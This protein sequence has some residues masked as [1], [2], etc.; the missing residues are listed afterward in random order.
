MKR[1]AVVVGTGPAGLSAAEV[2]AEAGWAVTVVD[3]LGSPGRKFL[4]AGVGGLNLTHSQ[5]F[6]AFLS[7]YGSQRARLEPYLKRFGPAELRA[8]AEGLGISLFTGTSGRVFPEGLGAGPLLSAWLTRLERQGVEVKCATRWVGWGPEPGP[9]IVTESAAGRHEVNA[10][11]VVLA[12]GGPTWPSLG[13][14]G[15]WAALLQARGVQL[16]PWRAANVGCLVD[17]TPV[18]R[19]KFAAHPLKDLELSFTDD[20][21]RWS[22]KGEL[23][24]TPWGLEGGL[25][26]AAGGR[27]LDAV[28]AGGAEVTLDLVPGRSL[29]RVEA[30][31]GRPREG[32][33][34]STHLKRTLGLEGAKVGLLREVLPPGS[35]DDARRVAALLKALTLTLTG[36]RPLE[37][38]ISAAG[39][40]R[41]DEV[42]P[43]LQ[44]KAVPGV[45]CAGEML[46]WEAPTG[47]YLLTACFSLGRA[48]G[49]AAAAVTQSAPRGVELS[50]PEAP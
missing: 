9:S 14:G 29:A 43:D 19:D 31:L 28:A 35:P 6:E 22:R 50:N 5:P 36:T 7:A 23:M 21:G 26:Y 8:W 37:E 2:L 39:G 48:A 10:D 25:L 41:W 34:L 20:Q 12:L 16:T 3:A 47:G 30:D 44:L 24:V 40:V 27:L 45:W 42:G 46:D 32:R 33:S 4:R 18:F 38:A 13:T 49:L 11:A 17:W 15:S 1:R